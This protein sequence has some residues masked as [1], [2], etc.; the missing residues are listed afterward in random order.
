M[1][2]QKQRVNF[3]V[4][5]VGEDPPS[6]GREGDVVDEAEQIVEE[7]MASIFAL[8]P[9]SDLGVASDSDF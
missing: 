7:Y 8:D 5:A 6:L 1:G 2:G 4:A 9:T 3:R